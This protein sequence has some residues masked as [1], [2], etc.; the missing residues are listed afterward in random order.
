MLLRVLLWLFLLLVIGRAVLRLLGGIVDGANPKTP[1]QGP[2][3]EGELMARDPV[4]GI[5]VVP[6][7]AVVSRD[8][9]GTHYFCSDA[10]RQA[11]LPK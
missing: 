11:Y 2:R 3:G 10:C 6:S 1:G 5:Y 4:C 7:R 8:K 9:A